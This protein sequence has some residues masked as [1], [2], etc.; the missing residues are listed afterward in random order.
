M[1]RLANMDIRNRCKEK[2]VTLWQLAD[3]QN[4]ADT[5]FSKHLRRELTDKKS[6]NCLNSLSSSAQNW[7]LIANKRYCLP[8][9]AAILNW[10]VVM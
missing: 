10:K 5:T 9:N 7:P 1:S 2:G 6:K 3:K 8:D 4:V